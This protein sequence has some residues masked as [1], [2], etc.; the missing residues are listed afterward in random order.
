MVDGNNPLKL[1]EIVAVD[2]VAIPLAFVTILVYPHGMATPIAT[3]PAADA[4]IRNVLRQL[5]IRGWNRSRLA[6]KCKWPPPRI[7]EILSGKRDF[8]LGTME[9]IADAF[10]LSLASLLI[11]PIENSGENPP[12]S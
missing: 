11:P 1:F 12:N 10:E 6:E 5:K 7:T 3:P 4:F 9:K 2:R 8:R